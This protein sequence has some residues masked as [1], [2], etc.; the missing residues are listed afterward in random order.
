MRKAFRKASRQKSIDPDKRNVMLSMSN[1]KKKSLVEETY[2]KFFKKEFMCSQLSES[3]SQIIL[4]VKVIKETKILLN[5]LFKIC[6][7]IVCMFGKYEGYYT[8]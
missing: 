8:M 2:A 3:T 6:Y 7:Q 5:I 4:F 1:F